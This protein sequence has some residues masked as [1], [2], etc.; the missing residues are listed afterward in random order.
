VL[1]VGLPVAFALDHSAHATS[2]A[3]HVTLAGQDIG[4]LSGPRLRVA[5]QHEAD[6]LSATDVDVHGPD[7]AF[8][9]TVHD[10][11]A[12]LDVNATIAGAERIDHRGALPGR[13]RSWLAGLL[14]LSGD[15]RAPLRVRYDQ[16]AL[17]HVVATMDPS[18]TPP[19]E[20][21]LRGTKT[22]FVITA[23]A[24]GR[25][26]D[27]IGLGTELVKAA[28]SGHL[29]IDVNVGRDTVLPRFSQADIE[30]LRATAERAV[31]TPLP[32]HAGVTATEIPT[33]TLTTWVHSQVGDH[34]QLVVDG[35]T[36]L[37][38]LAKALPD[39]GT[40]PVETTF[41]VTPFGI[42]TT[43]GT[44]GTGCC[45]G[46]ATATVRQAL[47]GGGSRPTLATPLEL[48]LRPVPPR[49]TA[50]MVSALGITTDIGH[51]TTMH[52]PNQPRVSNIHRMADLIRG[53]VILPGQ[54]FS[55]NGFVGPR[56]AEKGFVDAPVIGDNHSFAHDIG[57]GVSQFSTTLFNAA[58]FGGLDIAEYQAH[59]LYISRYPYGREATLSY[60]QPD[61]II[62]NT[63]PYGVLIW[64]TYT[65]TAI[66]VTLY[67]TPWAV[68][69]QTDQT[70]TAQGACT[71]VRTQRTRRY[72][73]DGHTT[74]DY[75][76]AF[77][78]PGEGIPC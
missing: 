38:D 77:Y 39:A 76:S 16:A 4:G 50:A 36:V 14:G 40:P 17:D 58:F 5:V 3:R 24:A 53:Q 1:V 30:Q 64:P 2:V 55:I 72:L 78:Y 66:T 51:F 43:P 56:T 45:D 52:P 34:L 22:G 29:P 41:A 59:G 10:L 54:S 7:T 26:L 25:G 47:F 8:F 42:T 27:A 11:G 69:A 74:V 75:F 67:S 49:I 68:G 6:R 20:P 15:Q 71:Q 37:A 23:S 32:V 65:D 35:P 57:G 46:S 73:Q 12:T 44:S 48:G 19:V 62:K 18:R 33:A 21:T 28:A 61:L 60:P 31:A 9:T 13:F 70:K 63:T